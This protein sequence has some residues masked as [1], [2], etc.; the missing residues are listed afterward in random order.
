MFQKVQPYRS[1]HQSQVSLTQSLL[2]CLGREEAIRVAQEN[3]W[4]GILAEL[5]DVSDTEH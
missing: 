1:Q 5:Q 2:S 3:H 4:G